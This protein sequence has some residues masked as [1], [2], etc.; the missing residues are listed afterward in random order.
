MALRSVFTKHPQLRVIYEDNFRNDQERRRA[1]IVRSHEIPNG[2]AASWIRDEL[3]A[4]SSGPNTLKRKAH[5][6]AWDDTRPDMNPVATFAQEHPHCHPAR[7]NQS[8]HVV[9]PQRGLTRPAI[10]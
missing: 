8:P 9:L 1:F 10:C 2:Y 7:H 6:D 5:P 3:H 4:M